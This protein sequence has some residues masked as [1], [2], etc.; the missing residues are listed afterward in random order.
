MAHDSLQDT[1]TARGGSPLDAVDKYIHKKRGYGKATPKDL[2]QQLIRMQH[3]SERFYSVGQ[4][5]SKLKKKMVH[6]GRPFQSQ[7]S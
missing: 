2:A 3:G 7:G 6:A 4:P 1:Y 5:P